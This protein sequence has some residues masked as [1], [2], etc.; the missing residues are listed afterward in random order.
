MLSAI[1]FLIDLVILTVL[2]IIARN[3][4]EK[5]DNIILQVLV[6]GIAFLI[7]K[8]IFKMPIFFCIGFPIGGYILKNRR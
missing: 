4:A 2:M 7:A 8:G 6:Y 1:K 5:T 3:I